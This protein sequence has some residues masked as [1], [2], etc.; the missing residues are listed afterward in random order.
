MIA[1]AR[2]V[3][4]EILAGLKKTVLD[5]EIEKTESVT[6]DAISRGP[7]PI[8]CAEALTEAMRQIVFYT[9]SKAHPM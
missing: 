7:D 9:N 3:K 2:R 5:C 6:K 8:K 4:Q 1:G